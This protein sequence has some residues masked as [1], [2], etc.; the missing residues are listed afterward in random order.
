MG[1]GNWNRNGTWSENPCFPVIL[2]CRIGREFHNQG[3]L[4]NIVTQ[5]RHT[6]GADAGAAARRSSALVRRMWARAVGG[7][8][9]VM[10]ALTIPE[11]SLGAGEFGAGKHHPDLRDLPDRAGQSRIRRAGST[12][13]Q[14]LA[15]V[16]YAARLDVGEAQLRAAPQPQIADPATGALTASVSALVP[17]P[18]I[19]AAA[20]VAMVSSIAPSSATSLSIATMPAGVEPPLAAPAPLDEATLADAARASL[21]A[22][23]PA[24]LQTAISDEVRSEPFTLAQPTA[25]VA[26]PPAEGAVA[27]QSFLP[28]APVDAAV[29][30]AV[31]TLSADGE[32][33]AAFVPSS[34]LPAAISSQP[35]PLAGA[36]PQGGSSALATGATLVADTAALAPA[37]AAATVDRPARAQAIAPL[38]APRAAAFAAQPV[39][40]SAPHASGL[41]SGG[42]FALAIQS[43]LVTRVDG[44]AAG[45]VDFQQT[46]AGLTVRLGSIVAVLADRYDPAQI[47]RIQS[48]AASNVY[49]SLVDLQAQGIPISYDPVYDEFNVGQTD[50]RPQSARKVHIDQISAPERGLGTAAIDQ[51]RRP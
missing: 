20:P 34:P 18:P 31:T 42:G 38:P 45:T 30:A 10:A 37:A 2:L 17:V 3:V 40:R 46:A 49:L 51:V 39:P 23:T 19:K 28:P 50:T 1:R 48:S 44:K 47:A 24:A 43:Q 41:G 9:M 11:F 14:P 5:A 26:A 6:D 7:S 21:A 36:V 8:V 35:V 25:G 32:R 15:G 16:R 12:G 29:A 13:W 4:G 33:A 22:V 27:I